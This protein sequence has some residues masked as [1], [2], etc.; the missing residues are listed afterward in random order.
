MDIESLKTFLVL[1]DTRNF[2]RAAGQL[3]VAQ[4]T[5]TNR[6]NELEKEVQIPLFT[7]NNRMVELTP[8]GEQFLV[9]AKKVID[10]TNS[11]LAEI[12]SLQKFDN[13][14]RIGSADSIYDGHLAPLILK[15]Q[16]TY[17]NDSIKITIG[18]SSHLLDLLQSNILDI[19]FTYLPLNKSD[20][21]CEI[22]RHD[23]M[24]LVTD[25]K[26]E[27]YKNGIT[28]QQLLQENYLMCNF[29]LQDVGQ[30]I[31]NLFPKYHQFAL[32]IDDCSK[33]IP[34]LLNQQNY[35]FLP[36]DMAAP[37]I[38]SKKLRLIPLKDFQTP[39]INSYIIGKKSKL[40]LWKKNF[41]E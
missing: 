16:Q 31:R 6:I 36:E 30:F 25:Y 5:V 23:P 35:T 34:F 21:K 19:V 1:S 41:K 15:H 27:K 22:F 12:S 40:E 2:T 4:S 29:A 7:R 9:Y 24:A 8:E 14:Y 33:I 26:N 3:F 28:A 39:I 32:E 18:L 13:R 38:E 17:P 11:S 37:Y 10:L 20:F